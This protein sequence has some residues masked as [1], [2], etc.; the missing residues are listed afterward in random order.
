[1]EISKGLTVLL[2]LI[3]YFFCDGKYIYLYTL[4]GEKLLVPGHVSLSNILDVIGTDLFFRINR[5]LLVTKSHYSR[6]NTPMSRSPA[7]LPA[8]P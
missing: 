6:L 7:Y 4:Q 8:K 5:N 2:S 3:S 1:M